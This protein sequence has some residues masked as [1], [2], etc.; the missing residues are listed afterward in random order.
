LTGNSGGRPVVGATA[1]EGVPGSWAMLADDFGAHP[2]DLIVDTSNT[3]IR[4]ARYYPL[5][6]TPLWAT[7][8]ND[9]RLIGSVDGVRLFRRVSSRSS[10]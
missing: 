3:D 6:S 2:P 7:V 9:Y 5:A 10:A 8:Q 4:G 1:D